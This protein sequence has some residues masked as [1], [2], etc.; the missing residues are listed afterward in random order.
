MS[1]DADPLPA[2]DPPPAI[3]SGEEW[4]ELTLSPTEYRRA[5]RRYHARISLRAI[6]FLA[7]YVVIWATFLAFPIAWGIWLSFNT[8]AS[9][10]PRLRRPRQLAAGARRQRTDAAIRNTSM[11]MVIAIGVVFVLAIFLAALL[12]RYRAGGNFFKVALYFPLLAP[13]ISER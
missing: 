7:P 9:S 13:P 1:V 3:E 11:Y 8:G 6:P 12:N 4:A 2:A 5:L 10:D